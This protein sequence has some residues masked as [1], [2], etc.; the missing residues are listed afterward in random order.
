[1]KDDKRIPEEKR[2]LKDV[3]LGP[4]KEDIEKKKNR[5]WK[6]ANGLFNIIIP[7]K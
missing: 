7:K 1:M 5:I 3:L 4:N 6:F 2:E